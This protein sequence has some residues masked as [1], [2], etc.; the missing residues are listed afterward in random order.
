MTTLIRMIGIVLLVGG[1]VVFSFGLR[2][3]Q[4]AAE[5]GVEKAIGRYSKGT[6]GYIIGGIVMT[7]AGT[8]LALNARRISK[9]G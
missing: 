7:V 6:M 5:R 8:G 1:I 9:E 2:S 3:S 4:H